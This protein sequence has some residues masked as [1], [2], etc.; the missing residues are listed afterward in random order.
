MGKTAAWMIRWSKPTALKLAAR[1]L[2]SWVF[3][4]C[5]GY[6]PRLPPCQ[7]HWREERKDA[8]VRATEASFW[9]I[10]LYGYTLGAKGGEQG[11]RLVTINT[12][13]NWHNSRR[14]RALHPCGAKF[15]RIK[16]L[17]VGQLTF[18]RRSSRYWLVAL[19]GKKDNQLFEKATY[20]AWGCVKASHSIL[21]FPDGERR[22]AKQLWR[23]C[24]HLPE[25]RGILKSIRTPESVARRVRGGNEG[26]GFPRSST[27]WVGTTRTSLHCD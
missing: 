11:I 12:K 6:E 7:K 1:G 3:R 19:A 9:C 14:R 8:W 2:M 15:T 17:K 4:Q 26:L 16:T 5:N 18:A 25:I 27:S 10:S 23:S 20:K 22:Y 21:W 13:R 24:Q